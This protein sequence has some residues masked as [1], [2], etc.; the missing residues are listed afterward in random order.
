MATR[1]QNQ[2]LSEVEGE[3]TFRIID[4]VSLDGERS[5]RL[6][7]HSDVGSV[8]A[9]SWHVLLRSAYELDYGR[10][11]KV[12]L[13]DDGIDHALSR[14][15]LHPAPRDQAP[16]VRGAGESIV[17]SP[18]VHGRV[19]A[20]LR[21]CAACPRTSGPA[22][23]SPSRT[24]SRTSGQEDPAHDQD[25]HDADDGR[26][27]PRIS[28]V[29]CPDSTAQPRGAAQQDEHDGCNPRREEPV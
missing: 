3:P 24:R 9:L 5:A 1:Q 12:N 29:R 21:P 6:R 14:E 17:I 27:E 28:A 18:T 4:G 20:R 19:V 8:G 11:T 23:A 25:P 15:Q 22:S 10:T 2:R 26:D 16:P 7:S 13:L